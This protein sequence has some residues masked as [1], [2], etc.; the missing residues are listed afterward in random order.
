MGWLSLENL[1]DAVNNK[2]LP[3]QIDTGVVIINKDNVDTYMQ[4]MKK[5]FEK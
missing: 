5:D 4:D 2:P 1:L 3:R